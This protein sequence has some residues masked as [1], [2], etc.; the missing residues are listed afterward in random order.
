MTS[1]EKKLCLRSQ[2]R[3]LTQ[4]DSFYI[5]RHGLETHEELRIVEED[6]A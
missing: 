2:C 6:Y 1:N 4:G 3:S 5:K